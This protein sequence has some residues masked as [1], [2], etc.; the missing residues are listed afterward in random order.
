MEAIVASLIAVFATSA[1]VLDRKIKSKYDIVLKVFCALFFCFYFYRLFQVDA[2]D[3]IVALSGFLTPAQTIII[4]I[5]RWLLM[6]AVLLATILPFV[7]VKTVSNLIALFVPIAVVLNIIFYRLNLL[8]FVGESYSVWSFRSIM[9]MFELAFLGALSALVLFRKIKEKDFGEFKKQLKYM[10]I[11]LPLA[12]LAVFP[13]YGVMAIFGPLNMIAEEFNFIHRIYLYIPLIAPIIITVFFKNKDY[14]VRDS[15]VKLLAVASFFQYFYIHDFSFAPTNLP[16]HLCNTGIILL[17]VAFVFKSKSVFYFT[18]FVNVIGSLFALVMP[19][20]SADVATLSSFQFWFNHWYVFFVPI[21]GITL[22]V[23][24]RPNLKMMRGA[25]YIF[26]IYFV[27]MMFVNG[28]I[29]TF[30]SVDYFFLYKNHIVKSGEFLRPIKENFIW[31]L[32][33]DGTFKIFWL[34]DILIY[35]GYIG[36][37]FLTWL[38]YSYG[39]KIIDHYTELKILYSTDILNIR[40]LKKEM[41]GRRITEPYNLEGV[42][43]VKFSHFSKRYGNSDNFAVKDFNFTVNDGEV[44]GFLGHNG[45]GKSTTIKSLVGIQDITEG[46]IEVCGY[47]IAKQPL[48]A[49]MQMGYVSDNHAVYEHL[50]GREYIN[51]VADLYN[52]SVSDRTERMEKYVKMFELDDAID[53]EIK[54]YSHGMKQKVMVISSII[55]NPKVWVLDEPL[56]GLDPTSSYQIKECMRAHAEAGNIVFFSSHV[57]E[58]VEKIC[59]R[60]VI[61]SKG[62]L[63]GSYSIKELKDKNISLEELYLN[64]AVKNSSKKEEL[65]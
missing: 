27:A 43:M 16:L 22:K 64:N 38:V 5:V 19:D 35:F 48:Q 63:K 49:K 62:Q 61:I 23:F 42:H 33:A 26:T 44:V 46:K 12:M 50:T 8:A 2:I 53:R 20:M 55:H 28:Y 60:I 11:I 37:M 9:F 1:I 59:D 57:I 17:V 34:Y 52:V 65:N 25:I 39:Y 30:S 15:V 21:L 18:Y 10:L 41:Q 3:K 40:Q 47:D 56:T 58:V 45:A 6:A 31:A 14:E 32:A 51:Y 54:S 24:S 13:Q 29:N 4:T 36:L 7:K